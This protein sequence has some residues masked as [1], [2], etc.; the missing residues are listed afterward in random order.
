MSGNNLLNKSNYDLDTSL[1]KSKASAD[2]VARMEPFS[3]SDYSSLL[4][5]SLPI[6][7]KKAAISKTILIKR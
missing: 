2:K 6:K 1:N 7:R 4:Y 5:H 3:G